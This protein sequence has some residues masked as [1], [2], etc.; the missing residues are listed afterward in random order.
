MDLVSLEG[1]TSLAAL[2]PAL[3]TRSGVTVAS[4]TRVSLKG[5]NSRVGQ[6]SLSEVRQPF[7]VSAMWPTVPSTITRSRVADDRCPSG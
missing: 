4:S 2:L 1:K 3:V 5:V 7:E 6:L